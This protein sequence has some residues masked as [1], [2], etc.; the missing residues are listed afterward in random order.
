[1]TREEWRPIKG[2]EYFQ[3]SSLG[4][5]RTI[6]RRV[7]RSDGLVQLY[8][9]RLCKTNPNPDGYCRANIKRDVGRGVSV[10]VHRL[11]AE[12]FLPNPDNLPVVRHL[13]HNRSNNVVSNLRW[14][15]HKDNMADRRCP[16]C[17]ELLHDNVANWEQPTYT[18]KEVWKDVDHPGPYQ[19]SNHGR[20]RSLPKEVEMR[21]FSGKMM[22]RRYPGKILGTKSRGGHDRRY[23]IVVLSDQGKYTYKPIHRLVAETFLPRPP[24][25]Q[26]VMHLDDNPLNNHVDNL[27]WGTYRENTHDIQCRNCQEYIHKGAYA[28]RQAAFEADA[29]Q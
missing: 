19:V 2:T 7:V 1:M 22:T 9:G 11:V 23:P 24:G 14:G 21:H 3:V 5:V 29:F 12:A 16:S 4:R 10:P 27:Q 20:V 17:N 6:P 13:D 8:P 26:L 18:D 15:T 28:E 25:A